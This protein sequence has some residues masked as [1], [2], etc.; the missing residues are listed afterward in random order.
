MGLEF[1]SMQSKGLFKNVAVKR[2]EE[3][4]PQS[5]VYASVGIFP[6]KLQTYGKYIDLK[7]TTFGTQ[8]FLLYIIHTYTYLRK[9]QLKKKN[10]L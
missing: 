2:K 8:F 10:F 6:F 5:G 1:L 9:C 4:I 7:L 3:C